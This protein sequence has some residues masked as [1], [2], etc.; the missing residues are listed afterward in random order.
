[1]WRSALTA[2]V[3]LLAAQPAA[4]QPAGAGLNGIIL[5]ALRPTAAPTFVATGVKGQDLLSFPVTYA[6][7]GVLR[8]EVKDRLSFGL[9]KST[10]PIP[11]GTPVFG[12]P[13]SNSTGLAPHPGLTWC[14]AQVEPGEAGKPAR[15]N[16]TCFPKLPD[17]AKSLKG[18]IVFVPLGADVFPAL[19]S[20]QKT[21]DPAT[22]PDIEERRLELNP[23]LKVA[24]V[25]DGWQRD[26]AKIRVVVRQPEHNPF[27][28]LLGANAPAPGEQTLARQ[29]LAVDATGTARL[30]LFGGEI[31]LHR[32]PDGRSA[33][34]EI[35]RP[36]PFGAVDR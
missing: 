4:T 13:M 26:L 7:T 30:P 33:A 16:V 21:Q 23:P 27:P 17:M 5:G 9:S 14:A 34:A 12:V 18:A 22:V 15:W 3:L 1:M 2:V 10:R 36:L 8:N 35:T 31:V 28:G 32:G 6:F 19:F 25:F 20:F 11:A 24:V 29:S